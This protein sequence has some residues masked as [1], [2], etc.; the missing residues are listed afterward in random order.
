[1]DFI[2]V[3]PEEIHT[4]ILGRFDDSNVTIKVFVQVCKY[5]HRIG[6]SYAIVRHIPRILHFRDITAEGFVSMFER[7]YVTSEIWKKSLCDE[8]AALNGDLEMLVW[9]ESK[10]FMNYPWRG[11]GRQVWKIAINASL[12]GHLHILKWI[13][14]R[15]PWWKNSWVCA[16]AALNGHL[17]VLKWARKYGC[18][19]DWRTCAS[20]AKNGHLEVL[21]WAHSHGCPWE[22]R[23]CAYAAYNKQWET[24]RWARENGCP[25]D[26]ETEE[27]AK[28]NW[29]ILF[30][31]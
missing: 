3:V 30:A 8:V 4:L 18:N 10:N 23:T 12:N 5:Y 20:A 26:P 21:R 6:S 17:E 9:A 2:R 28:K 7:I 1:M 25:W 29:Y 19:W 11:L 24:L 22:K 14:S 27:F 15:T 16:N 31:N 13:R